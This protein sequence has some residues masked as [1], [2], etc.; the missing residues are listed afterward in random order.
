[1]EQYF[2]RQ[3]SLTKIEDATLYFGNLLN[4]WSTRTVDLD[5]KHRN[6][7]FGKTRAAQQR[8]TFELYLG[9]PFC[10]LLSKIKDK[11]LVI[12]QKYTAEASV[13]PVLC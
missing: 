8:Y 4:Q 6:L 7:C 1:M 11:N 12:K 13:T 5:L 2:Y 9:E 10:M 3:K